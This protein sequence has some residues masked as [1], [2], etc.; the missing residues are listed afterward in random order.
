M[1]GVAGEGEKQIPQPAED[2]HRERRSGQA[3]FGMT[4][5]L[6]LGIEKAGRASRTCA[7]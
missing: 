5:V 4:M 3:G 7:D 1:A 2:A 6:G